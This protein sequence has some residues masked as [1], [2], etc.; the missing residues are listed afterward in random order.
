MLQD[1]DTSLAGHTAYWSEIITKARDNRLGVTAY[2]VANEISKSNYYLWFRR[3]RDQHPEWKEDLSHN[4]AKKKQKNRR[5]GV[6]AQKPTEVV[7]KAKRRTFSAVDKA[8]ILK[9]AAKAPAGQVAALL[10]REG[11]YTSH[12]QQWRAEAG[13]AALE[14]KQR[15]PLTNPLT[16]ENNKLKA[17]NEKL[18]KRLRQAEKIIEVQKKMAE[19]LGETIESSDDSE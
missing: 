16:A 6:Q 18:A 4:P 1:A 19:L 3:L 17:R 10:R 13:E 15:G 14:P 9:A 8:R 7:E 5:A 12:L 2:C 11:I